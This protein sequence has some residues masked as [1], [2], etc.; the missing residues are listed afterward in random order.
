MAQTKSIT[1]AHLQRVLVVGLSISALLLLSALVLAFRTTRQIDRNAG[2]FARQQ[3]I[4]KAAINNIERHRTELNT[5]W[6]ELARRRDVATREEILGQLAET[7]AE[8]GNALDSLYNQ[9]ERLRQNI[10]KEGRGLLQW[11]IWLFAV[12]VIL[13]LVCAIWV[14]NASTGLF[15]KLEQQSGELASMQYQLLE[16]QEAAMRRFSHELH[17][18]L[19]QAL[20]AVKANLS[21]LG[22]NGNRERVDDCMAL[23]DQAIHDVRELSQLLR[24][25]IL[26]DFGLDAALR[27]LAESFS[28]RTGIEAKYTSEIGSRR[29]PDETETNLYRIAQEALTNVA[30]HAEATSVNLDLHARAEDAMLTIRDN[31]RGFEL[32][33]RQMRAGLG[34]AGM[35]MRARGCGGSFNMDAAHGKGVKIEVKCPIAQ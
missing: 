12:C 26:D 15:H 19:G 31:G 7:R 25:T 9:A 28:Q 32:A 30:R 18:E 5:R 14:V 21:A 29:F 33:G 1:Q 27:S 20:T 3:S 2:L 35:R 34:L 13:S 11:T 17:D 8:M 10:H 16:T 22:T 6:L 24:P 4:A 23:I